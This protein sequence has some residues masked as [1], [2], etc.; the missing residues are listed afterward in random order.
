MCLF[1]CRL[2][3]GSLDYSPGTSL[4]LKPESVCVCRG[5]GGGGAK[6][7]ARG[8]QRIRAK[9]FRAAQSIVAWGRR[10]EKKCQGLGGNK[11]MT[12]SCTSLGRTLVQRGCS[13]SKTAVR[14]LT[15]SASMFLADC[16][17]LGYHGRRSQGPLL[18]GGG[19]GVL[20]SPCLCFYQ[21]M[22]TDFVR[23]MYS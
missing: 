23:K 20:E 2:P 7:L 16:P 21:S 6:T 11:I 15:S 8:D 1:K 17:A 10:G 22:C 5:G 19:G 4:L 14:Q 18:L 12:L 9:S 3:K 13:Q